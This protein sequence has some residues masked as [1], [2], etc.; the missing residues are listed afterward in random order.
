M[1]RTELLKH[2]P[3]QSAPEEV[4]KYVLGVSQVA[5][6]EGARYLNIDLFYQGHLRGRYFADKKSH[7]ANVNGHWYTCMIDNVARVCRGEEPRRGEHC[8]YDREMHWNTKQDENIATDYLG[9]ITIRSYEGCINQNKYERAIQRKIQRIEDM[10]N[11]VPAA[12]DEMD[13]WLLETVFPQDYLF[14]RKK[15]N[16]TE[17]DCTACGG[18]SWKKKGWKHNERTVCPKCGR[19]VIAYSRKQEVENK[20]PVVLLQAMGDEWV[21]RQMKAV[22]NWRAGEKKQVEVYEEIRTIIPKGKTWGKVWYGCLNRADEF[23]QEYWDKNQANK[24]WNRSLLYPGNLS[25]VLPYGNL[26]HSGLDRLSGD[27]AR[28]NVNSF[29]TNFHWR[30]WIE[31]LIKAGL[32]KLTIDIVEGY[33]GWGNPDEIEKGASSLAECLRLD[34][35]RTN[36]MKQL[37]GGLNALGWLQYEKKT[38]QMGKKIKISQESLEYLD[39]KNVY[40]SECEDILKE[41]GSVDRMV[42][43]MKKQS[44]S[45]RTLTGIWRDYLG[46]AKAEGMDTTDDI[47]RLPKDVKARHDELVERINARKDAKRIA[48]NREKY[49]KLNKEIMKRLPD[50]KRYFYENEKYMIIPAGKCEE[51]IA[52]GRK[53]HHCVASGDMYMRQ[54]AEGKSWILFLRKKEKLEEPYYTMEIRMKDDMI[55]Q[56]YSA[57]DRQ[58]D[59]KE[60]DKLLKKYKAS[61]EKQ[62]TT[63]RIPVAAIA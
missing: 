18:H 23:A 54:M 44:I 12:P 50:V 36:R 7:V 30:P 15:K 5:E 6:Y 42:N 53:L 34:G 49:N 29:I 40:M 55:L 20:M 9:G 1:K 19:P 21:E 63:V 24:K 39:R 8:Y 32:T 62:K 52:E 48:Q 17:Y 25:E 16:R 4:S 37:N 2:I 14:F 58:P 51:L 31:Y 43:Y 46:M 38:E 35:N 59:K 60:I 57:Y 45:P 28:F 41:L 56:Y 22:C 33:G 3:P 11:K 61:I 13:T 26:E 47:V 10:M 27:G